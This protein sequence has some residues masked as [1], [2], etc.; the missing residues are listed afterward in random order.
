MLPSLDGLADN[1]IAKEVERRL[2]EPPEPRRR[3]APRVLDGP[4]TLRELQDETLP[5]LD[6]STPGTPIPKAP[7]VRETVPHQ[8]FD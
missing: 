6:A 7:L 3:P 4:R 2:T 8:R 1:L 5:A